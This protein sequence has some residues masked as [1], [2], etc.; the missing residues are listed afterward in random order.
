MVAAIGRTVSAIPPP[1]ALRIARNERGTTSMTSFILSRAAGRRALIAAAALAAAALA[2]CAGLVGTRTVSLSEAQLDQ[3]LAKQFPM[4]RKVLEIVNLTVTNP[5]LHLLPDSNRIATEVDIAAVE[6]LSGS[7]AQGHL[8]LDYG[9]RFD[10]AEHAI[11][12]TD[13]HV[14]DLQLESGSGTL[15]GAAQRLGTLVAENALENL[16]LYRMKPAQADEMDRL[17]LQASPIRVSPDGIS[18]TISPKG[19]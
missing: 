9:L 7:H 14:R 12:M 18:M 2:G 3:Q 4:E 15:H 13:V 17:G 16:V 10:P 11:R 5:Q 1:G 19:Q 8:K 6:R